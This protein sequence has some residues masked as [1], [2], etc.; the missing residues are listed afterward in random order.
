VEKYP[1]ATHYAQL[2]SGIR[3]YWRAVAD[4]EE[5]MLGAGSMQVLE[6][7]N[8]LFL[9]E[10]SRVLGYCPQFTEYILEVELLG[11]KYEYLQLPRDRLFKFDVEAFLG[12]VDGSHHLIY[13]DNPNNPTGQVIPLREI[14][15]IV[16]AAQRRGTVVIVDEAYGDFMEREETSI[17]LINAYE[18]LIVVRSFSKGFGLP[19]LRVGYAVCGGPLGK[20]LRKVEIPFSVSSIAAAL[21]CKAL[22]EAEYLDWCRRRIGEVKGRLINAFRENRYIVAETHPTTPI[23]LVGRENT[24]LYEWL[25]QRNVASTPGSEFI[26]LGAHYVRIRT[27]RRAE[28]L[29]KAIS[30]E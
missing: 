1:T 10:G 25:L 5:V 30:L 21:A 13:I 19:G 27:P 18:N 26:G 22:E 7:I 20:L 14:E 4:V 11:A 8:L 6:R 9:G 16:E 24:N 15:E 12:R 2:R 3:E 28:P 17:R 23:F 29:L